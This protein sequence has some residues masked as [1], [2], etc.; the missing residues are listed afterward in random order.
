MKVL[1]SFR[2]DVL[3]R[4]SLD[5][6]KILQGRSLYAVDDSELAV[7]GARGRRRNQCQLFSI[8]L[9]LIPHSRGSS[10]ESDRSNLR[11]LNKVNLGHHDDLRSFVA[12]NLPQTRAQ[13]GIE[14]RFPPCRSFL[15]C[16]E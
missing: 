16:A 14:F 13:L 2:A 3:L 4:V 1:R 12:F 11:N 15:F 10:R 7:S 5:F 8:G 6:R 9:R